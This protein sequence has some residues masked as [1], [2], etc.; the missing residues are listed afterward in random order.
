M[1]I[2]EVGPGIFA[3]L[4]GNMT[5]NAGF[6]LTGRGVLVIDTLDKPANGRRLAQEIKSRT[7]QSVFLVINTHFHYDHTFGNQ[8]F[9]APVVGHE[10][11]SEL[12]TKAATSSLMPMAVATRLSEHPEDLWLVDE[13]ELVY[14]HI[15]FE[16]K[17]VLNLAPQHLVV[18]HLGG[19][20][21]D[22]SIV[23]LPEAGILF[24]G[25]LI[26]ED[27]VPFLRQASFQDT[28]KALRAISGLGERV[29]VPGHGQPCDT[30]YVDRMAD[31][32]EA[33]RDRVS[34][35]IGRGVDKAD[36][37][38]SDKL[39]EWWTEDRPEL[40]RANVERVYNELIPDD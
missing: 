10:S 8:A 5:A 19:H 29:I 40:V 17:L 9:D 35:L 28:I 37:L 21:P 6:V 30:T 26:F 31:Y 15:T 25:D 16:R 1:E 22:S 20:T 23:D 27:R 14:P 3:C 36:I 24:S 39:P 38:D 32:I 4:M 7:S 13:L 33:L 11:L 2:R 18:S 34:E 12:L